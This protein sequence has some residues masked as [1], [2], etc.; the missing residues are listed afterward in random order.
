MK[1]IITI[2]FAVLGFTLFSGA[3]ELTPESVERRL[4]R[5]NSRIEDESHRQRV[6][7][8]VDRGIVFQDI[9]DVNIQYLYFGMSEDELN[10]FMGSPQEKRRTETDMGVRDVWVY[11]NIEVYFEN[12]ILVGYTEKEVIHDNPLPEAYNSFLRA[13]EIH[14]EGEELGFFRRLFTANQES[15]IQEAFI[16]LNGQFVNKAVLHYEEANYPKAFEAFEYALKVADSPYFTEPVDTGLIFNTGFVASLAGNYEKAVEYLNRAKDMEFGEGNLYVM[17]K[18]AYIELG[19]ST[20]AERILQEGFENFPQDNMVLVE[21]VNYYMAADNAEAALTYLELAKE[22]E[23]DNPSF[24]Y[25]EGFLY[26]GMGEPE[27][28][29]EAYSRSLAIDP[30]FFDANYNMGVLYYNEAVKLLEEAN[31]I[32]D[33]VEYEKARDAAFEVLRQSVPYLEQ[34]HVANPDD[35]YTMETLRV[36]YY[37][38]GME[39]KLE[40]MNRKLGREAG[41]TSQ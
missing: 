8:W 20:M 32:M 39:D 6:K 35:E 25:A 24:H 5:S 30:D 19:D 22:Q 17:L 21:L 40:E 15:R 23:P 2:V 1:R 33:N 26:D 31:E 11:E 38:L 3:Q 12:G 14:E 29:K 10:L 18:D 27:K 28:A 4:E 41:D 13:I 7:T 36:L 37:R 9:F 16:R 34:A